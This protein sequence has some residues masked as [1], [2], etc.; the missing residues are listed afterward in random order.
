[1]E[2]DPLRRA[3]LAGQPLSYGWIIDAHAHLGPWFNFYIP[4]SDADGVIRS[5]DRLGIQMAC[6]TGLPALGPLIHQGNELVARAVARYPTRLLGYCTVNPHRPDEVADELEYWRMPLIKFHPYTHNYPLDGPGY[7]LALRFAE[8]HHCPVL[9]HIW[10]GLDYCDPKRL[11]VVAE[12]HPTVPLIAGHSGGTE[13]GLRLCV[14]LARRCPNVYLDPAGSSVWEG[15]IEFLVAGVGA[16]HVVMGTDA[17]FFDPRM[18]VGRIVF[19]RLPREDRALILG[20]TMRQL[21][22]NDELLPDPMRTWLS[23][24]TSA[25]QEAL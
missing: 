13:E 23:C 1:M 8:R 25:H 15:S 21:L 22:L 7:E 19:A 14:D 17:G 9:I 2:A 5:M 10:Q 3:L 4:A 24:E 20:E 18:Q 11:A 6:V 12:R 16:G